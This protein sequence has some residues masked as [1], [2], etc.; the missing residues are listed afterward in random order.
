MHYPQPFRSS[1]ALNEKLGRAAYRRLDNDSAPIKCKNGHNKTVEATIDN[2]DIVPYYP[3]LIMK[4]DCHICID[5]VTTKAVIAY[6]Y[7]YAYKPADSTRAKITYNGNEI[8]S[9]S[10]RALHFKL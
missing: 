8:R 7:K 3:Y 1:L 5:M 10:Q 2:R 6:I 4:Y 9:I